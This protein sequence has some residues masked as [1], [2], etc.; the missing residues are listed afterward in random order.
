M[1][2]LLVIA[3]VSV[4]MSLS[5]C[6]GDPPGYTSQSEE[7]NG[8]AA[9]N[10]NSTDNGK[11]T[12]AIIDACS[13]LTKEEV[14]DAL[15]MTVM[16]PTRGDDLV[17]RKEGTL[18]SSCMFGSNEGFVSL[19]IKQRAPTSTIAWNAARSYEE[20]K[21]LIIKGSGG[22]SS[23][24]FE[25]ISGLGAEAFAQTREEAENHE[26]TELRI[27]SKRTILTIRV[28]TLASTSTLE[29]AKTLAGKV[30]PRLESYESEDLVATT[31][32]PSA[33]PKPTPDLNREA[34]LK[35]QKD[36]QTEEKNAK[37]V[38]RAPVKKAAKGDAAKSGK[39]ISRRANEPSSRVSQKSAKRVAEKGKK[40]TRK[41][42]KPSPRNRR[43][44]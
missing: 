7:A 35:S 39:S 36:S 16:E 14:E 37:K 26:T 10:N 20:L 12:G 40:E 3:L 1:R 9:G 30:I 23:V 13:Q 43:R 21:N 27:L 2:R 42:V 28:N 41:I 22:Q 17:F 11:S 8:E 24:R 33:T 15:G 18:T 19:D 4:T 5:T 38:D 25:E 34:R 29:V 6:G 32:T 44:T 31:D